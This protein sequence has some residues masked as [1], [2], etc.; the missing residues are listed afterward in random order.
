MQNWNKYD[1]LIKSLSEAKDELS[2]EEI[3]GVLIRIF[4]PQEIQDL[5]ENLNKK[6]EEQFMNLN[7]N[8]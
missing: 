7:E 6:S 1:N 3:A 8:T 5:Q 4:S 2:K